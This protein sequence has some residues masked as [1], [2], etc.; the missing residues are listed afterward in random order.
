MSGIYALIAL[1]TGLMHFGR[2]TSEH[3]HRMLLIARIGAHLSHTHTCVGMVSVVFPTCP[4]RCTTAIT[5]RC[6]TAWHPN[7]YAEV[8]EMYDITRRLSLT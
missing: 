8:Y 5:A 7:A 2:G 6:L 3:V 1:E 4:V